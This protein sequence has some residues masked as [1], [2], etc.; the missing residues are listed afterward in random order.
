MDNQSQNKVPQQPQPVS[1]GPVRPV[2]Q[3]VV[4]SSAAGGV[5]PVAVAPKKKKTGLILGIVFGSI[6]LLAIIGAVLFYF[7]Y[8]QNPQ[9]VVADAFASVVNAEKGLVSG[10]VESSTGQFKLLMDFKS[11]NSSKIS[12]GVVDITISPRGEMQKTFNKDIKL[13]ADV[14]ADEEGTFYFKIGGVDRVVSMLGDFVMTYVDSLSGGL[15]MSAAQL[16]EIRSEVDK[17]FKPITDRL[18]DQWLKVSNMDDD[19]AAKCMIKVI[20]DINS[21]RSLAKDIENSYRE[22]QF[23]IVSDR[24]VESKDGA[25]GFDIDLNSREAQDKAESFVRSLEKTKLG[26]KLAEC[27]GG[28]VADPL[29]INTGTSGED[30]VN[31]KLIIWADPMTHKMRSVEITAESGGADLKMVFDLDLGKSNKADTPSGAKEAQDVIDD[32]IKDME[33]SEGGSEF[34]RGFMRGFSGSSGMSPYGS[35]GLS[36]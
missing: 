9:K 25:V 10:K 27:N 1:N 35:G 28:T 3:P 34:M 15:K 21:D 11:T 19:A 4:Q 13:K 20:K 33:S 26:K 5:A 12:S 30:E 18:N 24:K 36:I 22:N 2:Q 29:D 8:W 31:T 7:L 23:L 6:A 16:S 17:A 14:V 32:L